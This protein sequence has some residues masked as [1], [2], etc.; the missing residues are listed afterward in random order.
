MTTLAGAVPRMMRPGAGQNYP[1][2]GF[3]LEGK[4]APGLLPLGK[5]R[6]APCREAGWKQPPPRPARTA[7]ARGLSAPPSWGRAGAEP[8][9]G[10]GMAGA[11]AQKA[12][13]PAGGSG[14][15]SPS[16]PYPPAGGSGGNR[17]GGRW[18]ERALNPLFRKVKGSDLESP[19]LEKSGGRSAG[20]KKKQN[21]LKPNESEPDEIQRNC[22]NEGLFRAGRAAAS[23]GSSSRQRQCGSPAGP[24]AARGDRGLAAP[25]APS[26]AGAGQALKPG[27]PVP[28][29][30]VKP[31]RRLPLPSGAAARGSAGTGGPRARCGAAGRAGAGGGELPYR[32]ATTKNQ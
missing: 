7:H 25:V 13:L 11:A 3:P 12:W 17:P 9:P 20:K 8:C 26:S 14:L 30:Q 31:P 6:I 2:S 32:K 10:T 19:K 16:G 27:S 5:V 15:A 29:Q 21:K 1:R 23:G 28:V 4:A 24:L 22:R 18:C